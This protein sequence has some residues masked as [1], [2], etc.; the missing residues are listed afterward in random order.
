[1]STTYE[2]IKGKREVPIPELHKST[3]MPAEL[4]IT[5]FYGGVDRGVS[6][7]LGIL[8]MDWFHSIQ[9]DNVA[10]HALLKQLKGALSEFDT[11][12]E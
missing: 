11:V 7:Q 2:P 9:L 5:R 6:I 12:S 3:Y 1:M 8:D 10:A 4:H